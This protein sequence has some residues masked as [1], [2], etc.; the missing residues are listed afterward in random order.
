MLTICYFTSFPRGYRE[1]N[2]KKV[3]FSH[4]FITSAI[5]IRFF[6]TFHP[7]KPITPLKSPII[8]YSHIINLKKLPGSKIKSFPIPQ[9]QEAF[10]A[11]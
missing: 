11:L 8:P 10:I 2:D 6:C 7:Y 1:K 9:D 3:T 5:T 4:I